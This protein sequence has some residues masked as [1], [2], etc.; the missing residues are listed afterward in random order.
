MGSEQYI[1]C[2]QKGGSIFKCTNESVK[3]GDS[4]II[5]VNLSK[6]VK[7]T[8]PYFVCI[9]DTL[10]H[11][12]SQTPQYFTN[13]DLFM[14]TRYLYSDNQTFYLDIYDPNKPVERFYRCSNRLYPNT[15]YTFTTYGLIPQTFNEI[16]S[17]IE[18]TEGSSLTATLLRILKYPDGD[19]GDV[20]DFIE[21]ENISQTV[22][23]IGMEVTK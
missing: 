18:N 10:Y 5:K 13:T 16:S 19:Y 8:K 6:V 14:S 2:C 3:V 9:Y 7:E 15:S 17:I 21:N 12:Q 23:E 22:L 11:P 1:V 4:I 20:A